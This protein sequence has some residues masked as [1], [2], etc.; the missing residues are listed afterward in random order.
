MIYFKTKPQAI[1]TLL[2]CVFAYSQ[3]FAQQA[4]FCSEYQNVVRLF[5][6]YHLVPIQ[7]VSEDQRKD[8]FKYTLLSIDSKRNLFLQS[9]IDLLQKEFGITQLDSTSC[10]ESFV[11]KLAERLE[12]AVTRRDSILNSLEN[13][14]LDFSSGRAYSAMLNNYK[15]TVDEL[16]TYWHDKLCVNYAWYS[17]YHTD[18]S[19]LSEPKFLS[20]KVEADSV[21]RSY[22][23]RFK[24][25][26][27]QLDWEESYLLSKEAFM[28][29][30][31]HLYDPH[32]SYFNAT[33]NESFE[34]DLSENT[35]QTGVVFSENEGGLLAI[36]KVL[37]GSA[38]WNNQNIEVGDILL[39]VEVDREQLD[40]SCFS[41]SMIEQVTSSGHATTVKFRL[42]KKTGV[43]I[44]A[45]II[46]TQLTN[47]DNLIG[48][49]ILNGQE[50]VGYVELPGFYTSWENEDDLGCA[51]DVGTA[52]LRLMDDGINGL[53][54]D[55]R[56]NGGGSLYEALALSGAFVNE[57]SMFIY[58]TSG[59]KAR[60]RKDPNRGKVYNGPL[61]VLI[62]EYSA[63][64][65][66]ITAAILRDF[67]RAV[68]VGVPSY[69]KASGQFVIPSNFKLNETNSNDDPNGF[70]KIT[71]LEIHNLYGG[72]HQGNGLTPDVVLPSIYS[73]K[74]DHEADERNALLFDSLMRKTYF[75]PEV[76]LP[77][78]KLRISGLQRIEAD[79]AGLA[80][81]R[82]RQRLIDGLFSSTI[83]IERKTLFNYFRTKDQDYKEFVELDYSQPAFNATTPS[84]YE[85]INLVSEVQK[86]YTNN[87]IS[88]IERD[89]QITQAYH[90][91]CNLI[92]ILNSKK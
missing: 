50:P 8:L 7:E 13:S 69:G 85:R 33:Q 16:A 23:S 36:D 39:E 70:V 17:Y 72:S 82:D 41:S 77:L 54:L 58:K 68:I 92:N 84:Y 47:Q 74:T 89:Y 19:D 48:A 22:L 4:S 27:G 9:D 67:N 62:D 10:P 18:S 51:N 59:D 61:V 24:C 64:A 83:T 80:Y 55:L 15:A 21:S 66:E 91:I 20:N 71:H 6:R 12:D 44:Q 42:L 5:A 73:S 52:V 29:A 35:F 79:T 86:T 37:Q 43:E 53:I 25:T 40:L 30:Y 32:S 78:E 26:Y 57:G 65:S 63:S 34:S 90:V 45:T 31:A 28:V 87:A 1:V 49:F 11:L 81:I 88:S 3:S 14:E 76:E 75:T 46:T 38:A 2:F 60:L 56:G